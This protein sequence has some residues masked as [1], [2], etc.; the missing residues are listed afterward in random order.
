MTRYPEGPG[1]GAARLAAPSRRNPEEVALG[2][3]LLG[4]ASGAYLQP[5]LEFTTWLSGDPL[6]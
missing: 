3:V 2:G 5:C 1:E 4:R 6:L